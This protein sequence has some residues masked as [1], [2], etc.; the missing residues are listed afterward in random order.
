[1]LL[2]FV[3]WPSLRRHR[4]ASK[5][6]P[7]LQLTDEQWVLIADL[8]PWKPPT[9][10]GGRPAIPPRPCLEGILWVL[11]SGARWKD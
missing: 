3:G 8:F 6:E 9:R 4:T 5:T 7:K 1:M 11:R 2:T 10:K